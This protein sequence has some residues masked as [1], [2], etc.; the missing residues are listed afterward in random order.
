MPRNKSALDAV[1]DGIDAM[2]A[3]KCSLASIKKFVGREHAHVKPAQILSALKKAVG[4]G[5]LEMDKASYK[6]VR[7]GQQASNSVG[8]QTSKL[9]GKQTSKLVGKQ[10]SKSVGAQASKSVGKQASKSAAAWKK[11]RSK[12]VSAA[13]ALLSATEEAKEPAEKAKKE[14]DPMQMTGSPH[15]SI[16]NDDDDALAIG[17]SLE[18]VGS[19]GNVYI[20]SREANT[21]WEC[22]CKAFIFCKGPRS[23]KTCTH[24]KQVKRAFEETG[25]KA[26][27]IRIKKAKSTKPKGVASKKSQG[28]ATGS[29]TSEEGGEE[30]GI[31]FAGLKVP[32]LKALLRH[33]VQLM[34]GT[35]GELLNRVVDRYE[36]GNLPACPSCGGGRLKENESGT[37]FYCPGYYDDG[38]RV[39]CSYRTTE[40][41]RT[42]FAFPEGFSLELLHV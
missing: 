32:E 40:P 24:I 29:A 22:T 17:E 36:N 34:G 25:V 41:A 12:Q 8:K 7:D 21:K 15:F 10:T 11:D 35:K 20:V 37:S 9:V 30:G 27:G 1:L 26:H 14:A 13:F 38:E 28:K 5:I 16:D 4:A 23:E 42:P 19:T 3:S 31:S 2:N 33:N 39:S 6:R 18:V